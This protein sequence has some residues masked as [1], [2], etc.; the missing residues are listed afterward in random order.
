MLQ[1]HFTDDQ[2]EN[3]RQDHWRKLKSNAVPTVFEFE[4]KSKAVSNDASV[5]QRNRKNTLG[6]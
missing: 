3:N 2:F 6:K 1:V 4:T 5:K